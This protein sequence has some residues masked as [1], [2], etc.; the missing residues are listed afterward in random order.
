MVLGMTTADVI[1]WTAAGIFPLSYLMKKP[2]HL[3]SIQLTAATVWI[4][5]GIATES[6]PVIVA[7]AITVV[8]GSLSAWRFARAPAAP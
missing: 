6:M 3:V 8:A 5:F 1:G 7:N 2:L 4:A